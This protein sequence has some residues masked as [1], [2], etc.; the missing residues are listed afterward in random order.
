[1]REHTY[2][3]RCVWTG[4]L[5]EGTATYRAYSR[6]HVIE[7]EGK[8]RIEGS[9]DPAFRGDAS[10]LNPEDLFL[11]SISSCHMLWY[12]HLCAEAGLVLR[13]YE[14]DAKATMREGRTGGAFEGAVLRPRCRFEGRIGPELA[15]H[16]HHEAHR[17][18][19]IA[20]SV[21][22]AVTIEATV[23]DDLGIRR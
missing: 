7:I 15:R 8:A 22:F 4:D 14:D 18:C 23:E 6:D 3:S 11:A 12:L 20:N 16:L 13:A 19:F 10:R 17:H 5:G 21:S 1:M 2:T 9:A